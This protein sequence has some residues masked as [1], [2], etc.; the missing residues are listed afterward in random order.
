MLQELRVKNYAL[1]RNLVFRPEEGLNVITGETGAGKSIL[2]GALGLILGNRADQSALLALDEKCV[3]EGLFLLENEGLKSW[4]DSE[5]LDWD[6]HLVLRREVIPGGKSRSFINDTPVGLQQLKILGEALVEIQTQ[7][8]IINLQDAAKQ[9]Q[10][11]DDFCGNQQLLSEYQALFRRYRQAVEHKEALIQQKATWLKER[12]FL[13]FQFQELEQFQPA[14]EE[15]TTLEAQISSLSHSAEIA[16]IAWEAGELLDQPEDG[17]LQRLSKLKNILK[18][19]AK[20]EPLLAGI[21]EQVDRVFLE[22]RE[23]SGSLSGLSEQEPVSPEHLE[24]L[25]ERHFKLQALLKKHNKVSAEEL[26]MLK[27]ELGGQLQ[28]GDTLS[29]LIAQ[30]EENCAQLLL[31][32]NRLAALLSEQ[33][34]LAKK[35]FTEQVNEVLSE[36]EMQDASLTVLVESLPQAGIFGAD[37]VQFQFRSSS[38][39]PFQPLGRVA[40]GG[41][42][43]RL[44]FAIQCISSKKAKLPLLVFDEADSGVSGEVA[45]KFGRLLRQM[46]E[47]Q[48]LIAITHL[49]QVAGAGHVHFYVYKE[50]SGNQPGSGI[51]K[52]SE[53]D[54]VE[55][56]AVMM[57]G[58]NPGNSARLHAMNLLKMAG[59]PLK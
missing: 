44:M 42:L 58:K 52:L 57:S 53:A 32:V 49:P 4:F 28:E 20:Y 21:N 13:L 33:R 17:L 54:R 1:I 59:E 27:D 31:E 36:L 51:K 24:A 22:L 2:L 8:A 10:L 14:P 34:R 29:E 40:S 5:D 50:K 26:C 30:Q 47:N 35:T 46:A 37:Q 45:L 11:L 38:T 39:L 18:N 25:H 3:V 23:I 12:D 43:S 7:H 19:G 48:Q 15:E 6:R 55:E 56:L 16:R 9:R 41:E